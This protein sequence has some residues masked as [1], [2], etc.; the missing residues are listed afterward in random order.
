MTNENC[1]EK[2]KKNWGDYLQVEVTDHTIIDLDLKLGDKI[3][4]G[5]LTGTC[6][7]TVVSINDKEANLESGG[8]CTTLFKNDDNKWQ[9]NHWTRNIDSKSILPIVYEKKVE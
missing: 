2:L 9:Y 1:N 3:R 8:I 7:F 4:L 6:I 5:T